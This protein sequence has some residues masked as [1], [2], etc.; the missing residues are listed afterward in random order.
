MGGG[1]GGCE[2]GDDVVDVVGGRGLS[3]SEIPRGSSMCM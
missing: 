3:S 2:R 1:G